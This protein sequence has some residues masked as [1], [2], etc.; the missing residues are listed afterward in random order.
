M[1]EIRLNNRPCN[2]VETVEK[3]IG[4]IEV[5]EVIRRLDEQWKSITG[6]VAAKWPLNQKISFYEQ[7]Q[8][9]MEAVLK[10][11]DLADELARRLRAISPEQVC[12]WH[13]YEEVVSFYN[14]I[15]AL[16][17]ERRLNKAAGAIT[18]LE[19]YIGGYLYSGVSDA[20]KAAPENQALSKAMA[21]RSLEQYRQ[22]YTELSIL[23]QW[24]QKK[25]E[26]DELAD[27]IAKELPELIKSLFITYT[28]AVWDERLPSSTGGLEMGLCR[29]LACRNERCGVGQAVS[30]T[31]QA[32][33]EGSSSN[34]I[35]VGWGAGLGAMSQPVI[36]GRPA[37]LESLAEGRGEGVNIQVNMPP[38]I[39][40]LRRNGLKSAERR[41]R[42]GLCLL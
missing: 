15:G 10:L 18:A 11:G 4:W 1:K 23:W 29:P 37:E 7:C 16:L 38:W 22:A 39:G 31:D 12:L 32:L 30:R 2:S 17:N 8:K 5:M 27:E 41:F 40:G 19:E 14:L 35:P 20:E 34:S 13:E 36:R 3:L 9:H 6:P 33:P 25:K 24:R 26:C 42:R 21:G 28:D